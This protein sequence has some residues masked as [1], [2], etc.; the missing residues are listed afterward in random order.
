MSTYLY[1]KTHNKTGLKYLGKTIQN[2]Y[3]YKGS[4]IH[5]CRHL[6]KHG[7]DVTTEILKECQNNDEVK[8]WGQYYSDLWNVVDDTAWANLKPE[9]GD[10]GF[11]KMSALTKVK[12]KQYQESKI[13]S[14]KAVQSR[15][16]NCLKNADVRKGKSWTN[17]HRK[18]RLETYIEKNLEIALKIIELHDTGLSKLKVS[19]QL[20]V[21]WEKVKYSVL[22]REDFLAFNAKCR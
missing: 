21:S 11:G 2:P 14:E 16:D 20:G 5:W 4:G 22:H 7:N 8:Y 15:L 12:I 9:T 3:K 6:S 19:Q 1:V 10:G 13:W 18:S 17:A